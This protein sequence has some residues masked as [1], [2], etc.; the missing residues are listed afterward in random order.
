[1]AD[2]FQSHQQCLARFYDADL[3]TKGVAH[4]SLHDGQQ[5]LDAVLEFQHAK[6]GVIALT[7]SR[8]FASYR[9]AGPRQLIGKSGIHD[10][11]STI[12]GFRSGSTAL[13]CSSTLR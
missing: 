11:S 9:H 12:C 10:A 3:V 4:Q 1:M 7:V 8:R 2:G 13:K 6:I 5:V